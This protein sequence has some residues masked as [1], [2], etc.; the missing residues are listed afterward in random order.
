LTVETLIVNNFLIK[1]KWKIYF[2]MCK[3]K[4]IN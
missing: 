4:F 1:C 3:Q 2:R